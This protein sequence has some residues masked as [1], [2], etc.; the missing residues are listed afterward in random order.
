MWC[1]WGGAPALRVCAPALE[2]SA[3]SPR[4]AVHPPV[5]HPAYVALV[6]HNRLL[7]YLLLIVKASSVST[8]LKPPFVS[9][10]QIPFYINVIKAPFESTHLK[11]LLCQRG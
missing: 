8:C 5:P 10:S 6:L 9:L 7:H 2:A 3:F 4:A 1:E 11:P